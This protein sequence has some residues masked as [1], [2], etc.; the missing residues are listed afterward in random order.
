LLLHVVTVDAP[1]LRDVHVAG[2]LRLLDR[3]LGK[4]GSFLRVFGKHRLHRVAKAGERQ[5]VL[6]VL[7]IP[8]TVPAVDL[9]IGAEEERHH[10]QV[11]VELQLVNVHVDDASQ[12]HADEP[13]GQILELL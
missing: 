12:T 10:G 8:T 9:A 5:P 2:V 1:A 13:V 11:E 3:S 6:R 7:G 4:L